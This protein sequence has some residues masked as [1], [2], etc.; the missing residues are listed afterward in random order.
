MFGTNIGVE[1]SPES[2]N[3]PASVQPAS[4]PEHIV[5]PSSPTD[6]STPEQDNE[7]SVEESGVMPN[8]QAGPTQG[9]SAKGKGKATAQDAAEN[10]NY[11]R[12]TSEMK[13]K[14][15]Q[16]QQQYIESVSGIIRDGQLDP[17]EVWALL[18][19]GLPRY[20]PSP[21]RAFEKIWAAYRNM[22][23]IGTWVLLNSCGEGQYLIHA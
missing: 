5:N 20:D 18:R 15:Y 13:L 2:S 14:V 1:R 3:T 11:K 7:S 23:D 12:I 6:Q 16:A 9:L 10:S 4:Y 19:S 22:I 21:W 8:F 17:G